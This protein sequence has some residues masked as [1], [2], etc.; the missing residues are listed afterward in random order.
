MT[1]FSM[2]LRDQVVRSASPHQRGIIPS[3]NLCWSVVGADH[4]CS[5]AS[6]ERSSGQLP[7]PRA[8]DLAAKFPSVARMWMLCV[9]AAIE[10][11]AGLVDMLF[12]Y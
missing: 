6:V 12:Y 1:V 8:L 4:T 3:R 10:A 11:P 5:E 7:S 2:A 9:L